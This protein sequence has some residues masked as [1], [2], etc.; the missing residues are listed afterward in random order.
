MLFLLSNKVFH[1]NS[2][3]CVQC[4][5]GMCAVLKSQAIQIN[6]SGPMIGIMLKTKNICGEKPVLEVGTCL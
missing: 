1:T 4:V 6:R 2:A 5:E 3:V